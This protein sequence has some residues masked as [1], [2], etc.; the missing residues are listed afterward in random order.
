MKNLKIRFIRFYRMEI[1]MQKGQ[2]KRMLLLN[3][4]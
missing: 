1:I 2:E 4:N 3:Q